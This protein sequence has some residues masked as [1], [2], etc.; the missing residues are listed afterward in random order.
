M[1]TKSKPGSIRTRTRTRYAPNSPADTS[2]VGNQHPI[3]PATP[4]Q[5]APPV[6]PVPPAQESSSHD[7]RQTAAAPQATIRKGIYLS[8]L[9][10]IEGDLAAADDFIGPAT[11]TLKSV[12][13]NA[14]SGAHGGLTMTLKQVEVRNDVEQGDTAEGSRAGEKFQF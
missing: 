11:T 8:A 7:S 4:T 5:L 2:D 3:Q 14:L 1:A 12:L 6:P 9:I 10:Y 13:N